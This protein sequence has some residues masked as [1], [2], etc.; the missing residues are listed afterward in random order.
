[1][2]GED[3]HPNPFGRLIEILDGVDPS[4]PLPDG[5][6]IERRVHTTFQQ[7]WTR[8]DGGERSEALPRLSD[9]DGTGNDAC[10][11]A[12]LDACSALKPF[13]FTRL[14]VLRG[15][16]RIPVP[17]L[18]G[19]AAAFEDAI[20]LA[21]DGGDTPIDSDAQK[22][23]GRFSTDRQGMFLD[24]RGGGFGLL[25]GWAGERAAGGFSKT[26]EA[27]R[28]RGKASARGWFDKISGTGF[29]DVRRLSGSR[30]EIL[31]AGMRL[32]AFLGVAHSK[33]GAPDRRGMEPS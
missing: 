11:Q 15:A 18:R 12:L 32:G 13:E 24:L 9:L 2:S 23:S 22:I 27:I 10:N 26:C 6:R 7:F 5:Y 8:N 3:I 33:E 29:V 4:T 14:H 30:H 17:D 1:M 21:L 19:L 28:R 20:L 31:E 25:M 16:G